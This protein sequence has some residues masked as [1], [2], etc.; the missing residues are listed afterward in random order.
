M[1]KF[2]RPRSLAS[3][4]SG[5]VGS[6]CC[7]IPD[8][9]HLPKDGR[10]FTSKDKKGLE[11]NFK[12][13]VGDLIGAG[14]FSSVFKG[15][16]WIDSPGLERAPYCLKEVLAVKVIKDFRLK[17][18]GHDFNIEFEVHDKLQ[19]DD[20]VVRPILA[21]PNER[22]LVMRYCEK[23]DLKSYLN[24]LGK[25]IVSEV[26]ARKIL[27]H[28]TEGLASLLDKGYFHRDIKEANVFVTDDECFKIGDFGLVGRRTDRNTMVCG[29]KSAMAPEMD[30]ERVYD[31]QV[32]IWS[33]G[34]LLWNILFG[35][36]P[37]R[38]HPSESEDMTRERAR[39][40]PLDPRQSVG[41]AL[42]SDDCLSLLV[43]MLEKDPRKR[44]RLRDLHSMQ[45]LNSTSL[46]GSNNRTQVS[47]DSGFAT[48]SQLSR[49]LT[50]LTRASSLPSKPPL[51]RPPSPHQSRAYYTPQHA[52]PQSHYQQLHQHASP[53][54][55]TTTNFTSS[56]QQPPQSLPLQVSTA[57]Y[58]PA[59]MS[60]SDG[61][62]LWSRIGATPPSGPI[63]K[64]K[65][66][67]NTL[68]LVPSRKPM[69]ISG[70]KAS[71]RENGNV[72]LMSTTKS[73]KT[74]FFQ[75]SADGN[76]INV[77]VDDD[78]LG[79]FTY[80]NLPLEFRSKYNKAYTIVNI[81]KSQTPK[82]TLHDT[83]TGGEA[84]DEVTCKL[85]E[86]EPDANI[87]AVFRRS[88]LKIKYVG[89]PKVKD[90]PK[91]V[92]R[93]AS[94]LA[95]EELN[96]ADIGTSRIASRG[97]VEKFRELCSDVRYAGSLTRLQFPLIS[98]KR[99]RSFPGGQSSIG[100]SMVRQ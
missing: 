52:Q 45:I 29:T 37:F 96:P 14:G 85:M 69:E 20:K 3:S 89:D 21:I 23:K 48:T 90:G 34:I 46:Y 7:D 71:I 53:I 56:S 94:G 86:N 50:N 25:H 6:H 2:Y 65:P 51:M 24:S 44:I 28:V 17:N 49:N 73:A 22:L 36:H 42:V 10:V 60:V 54:T 59:M 57:S 16:R 97:Q 12:I 15:H 98:G 30:G 75:V 19:F 91:A 31:E 33:L 77:K 63:P 58:Q 93:I 5:G 1:D 32:D 74:E 61:Q 26:E 9:R 76:R 92:V 38:R 35:R 95:K 82:V 11:Y 41:S 88:G 72:L 66:K 43:Q 8:D 84:A 81:V 83:V 68:R 47:S 67:L 78:D 39:H 27:S 99:P 4:Y 13:H 55:P 18:T 64:L 100:K 79:S 62:A 87:E 80:D 70:I 40:D